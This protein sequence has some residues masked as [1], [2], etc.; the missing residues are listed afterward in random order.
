MRSAIRA[1]RSRSWVAST[2][3]IPNSS[4]SLTMSLSIT[5]LLTGSRSEVGSSRA[6]TRG[7]I[8]TIP[9]MAMSRFSPPERE[10][11][12]LPARWGPPTASS[13]SFALSR[14]SSR[15]SPR[16]RGP[17][18]TSS[19]TVGAKSWSS[20]S[21]K[22]TP[23]TLQREESSPSPRAFPL[24]MIFP[25][26]GVRRPFRCSMRVDFPDPFGPQIA[27]I[28]SFI[29][30]KHMSWIPTLPSGYWWLAQS[31]WM[32]SRSG[33]RIG[34][35]PPVDTSLLVMVMGSPSS[36][37]YR[38]ERGGEK[39]N[40]DRKAPRLGEAR[41]REVRHARVRSREPPGDHRLVDPLGPVEGTEEDEAEDLGIEGTLG[42]KAFDKA[43]SPGPD[44]LQDGPEHGKGE[45]EEPVRHEEDLVK[46]GGEDAGDHP[47]EVLVP[48]GH[49]EEEGEGHGDQGLSRQGRDKEQALVGEDDGDPHGRE[50]DHGR[51]R[52]G[53]GKD[54]HEGEDEDQRVQ[55][56]GK[57]LP[58][59]KAGED[60]QGEDRE[61]QH[62]KEDGV[63]HDGDRD[64]DRREQE[65]LCPGAHPGEEGFPALRVV[66]DEIEIREVGRKGKGAH[67]RFLL[68][69]S[70]R[71]MR[72]EPWVISPQIP[73][74]GWPMAR[75]M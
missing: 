26:E 12:S 29:T 25:S 45:E 18:I 75:Q 59:G 71:V 38:E 48:G 66:G 55:V 24:T 15:V 41:G 22:T 5:S 68:A 53:P 35:A 4:F 3:P 54:P 32:I 34:Q 17:N 73:S 19:S 20:A 16:F 50:T 2:T 43:P 28:S 6:M 42:Q 46:G 8:A 69:E 40:A 33:S 11:G 60:E 70:L 9:A 7:R 61:E 63:P 39:S 74:R 58:R 14:A 13:A 65:C 67:G 56:P 62:E 72:H 51:P 49:Q 47:R 10:F 23:T 27:T 1:A 30:W 31:T 52:L 21:W 64:N 44:G 57:E 37:G 36:P